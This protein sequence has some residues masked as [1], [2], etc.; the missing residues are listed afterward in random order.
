MFAQGL[1]GYTD[2]RLAEGAGWVS[3]DAASITCPVTVLHDGSD[4]MVDVLH[5]R[6]TAAII[7]H[8]RLRVFDEGGHFSIL[9]Q[10]VP[11]VRG[12]KSGLYK[13]KC[14]N[15]DGSGGSVMGTRV[16]P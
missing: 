1:E 12:P 5:A 8:A 10:V 11:T 7:P 16:E 15:A 3:F 9:T 6:H 13:G 14:V 4:R 2:D